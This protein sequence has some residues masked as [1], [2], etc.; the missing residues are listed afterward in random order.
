MVPLSL[1]SNQKLCKK[2]EK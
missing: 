1:N 2:Q